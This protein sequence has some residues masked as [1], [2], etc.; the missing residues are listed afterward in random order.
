MEGMLYKWTN[1]L[2]GWQPRWFVLDKGILTYYKS[3]DEMQQGCKG[4]VKMACCEIQVH[5]TDETRLDLI[6]PGEQHFYVRGATPADRQRWLVA[7]GSAKACLADSKNHQKKEE[8]ED[9]LRT[10]MS[11]LRLYC[12]LLT[13]Q[14]AS[15]K[16]AG[17]SEM[18]PPDIEKLNESSS[19]LSA[20]CDTFIMTLQDC[21]KLA[22]E[23][24]IP[25]INNMDISNTVLPP[26][27]P[28]SDKKKS[29]VQRS[30]S[31]EDRYT[32][33]STTKLGVTTRYRNLE[34]MAARSTPRSR[35]TSRTAS[36]SSQEGVQAAIASTPNNET[37]RSLSQPTTPTVQETP[38]VVNGASPSSTMEARVPTFFSELSAKFSDIQVPPD[39]SIPTQPFLDACTCIVGV[40]DALSPT[41][42]APVK[43]DVNGNIRKLRQKLSSDPEMF[44]KLQAMVQ[45]EVRTKTTQVKN[46]A[47]DALMWLRRTLEF[48]QEFLSEILTG[49]RDMNLAATNAYGRT[50]KKYHGWVVRGV[51]AL[52]A[53]AVPSMEYFLQFLAVHKEDAERQDF[54]SIILADLKECV[55]GLAKLTAIL[56]DHY[57]TGGLESEEIV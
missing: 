49:E 1:Y 26:S 18:V 39:N 24:F 33:H 6:I 57:E 8:S 11:E 7:L 10:K 17:S 9:T 25:N 13:Q 27:T 38:V 42:F 50:L 2:A 12:D 28:F 51:F 4:S 48:I 44:M 34:D 43:M 20:T 29:G 16:A 55:G 22:K 23:S 40:F 47:T 36:I 32:P 19:L 3:Q 37:K 30:I 15:V 56:K 45:Q 54:E 41:A 46:S 53:K 52:A 35:P 21:M 14:V 31:V 5:G